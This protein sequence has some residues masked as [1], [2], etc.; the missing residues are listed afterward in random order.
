MTKAFSQGIAALALASTSLCLTSP[1]HSQ[2][3][4]PVSAEDAQIIREIF[5]RVSTAKNLF[6][7]ARFDIGLKGFRAIRKGD[8]TNPDITYYEAYENLPGALHCEYEVG[9]K[10]GSESYTCY[11]P[12]GQRFFD[13]A[14]GVAFTICKREPAEHQRRGIATLASCQIATNGTKQLEISGGAI[15][16]YFHSNKDYPNSTTISL[17][18]S[19]ID[20]GL[21]NSLLNSMGI[22][23]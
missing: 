20:D 14:F 19:P 10:Y 3:G 6:K 21:G 18:S 13:I 11:F 16:S 22:D 2:S 12:S 15:N 17:S 9:G 5:T 4:S 7:Y 23:P 8:E 1:A